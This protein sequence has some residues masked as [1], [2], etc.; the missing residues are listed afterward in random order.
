MREENREIP[1]PVIF[2]APS[3]YEGYFSAIDRFIR[4]TLGDEATE[5]Y[6]IVNANAPQVAQFT[7]RNLNRVTA[8]R[9]RGNESYAFNWGLDIPESMQWPFR[10]NHQN[11]AALRLIS[12]QPRAELVAELRRAF[13]G[14][15]AGNVKPYGIRQIK[16]LGPY[17]LHGEQRLMDEIDALLKECVANKRMKITA[18]EYK[19]CYEL[20]SVPG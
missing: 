10:V 19:P 20:F 11:M 3:G 6:Q 5:Y 4:N 15:V 8:Q 9:R 13:S 14:I 18:G 17:R 2:T 7:L 1:V 12:D 16:Q